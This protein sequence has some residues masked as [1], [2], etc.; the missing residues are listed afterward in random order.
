MAGYSLLSLLANAARGPRAWPPVWR[1]PEPKRH[2][3]VVIVGGGGHGLATAHYLA[4]QYGITDVAVLEKGWLGGGNTAR[5][6]TIVRSDYRL[7]ANGALMDFSLG[8]WEGL[9]REL[10]FNVM[11][12]PRGYVDLAHSDAELEA[13]IRRA[14]AMRLRG[15]DVDILDRAGLA[16][17]VPLLDCGQAT[18]FPVVGALVQERGGT[19]RH[20][21]VAWGYARGA[22][23]L[24]VDI[25]QN[26]PVSGL[27]RRGNRITGV[28]TSRGEIA[29]SRILLSVSGHSSQLAALAGL[30]LPIETFAVQAFVSEP[31][32]PVLDA[33]VNFNAGMAYVSQTAKGE[34]L[35]GGE[36]DRYNCYVQRGGFPRI[37]DVVRRTIA[38]FPFLA[39]LRLM[40]QWAGI[41][42]VT[43]DGG[44]ILGP[45]TIEGLYLNAG[46]G[47]SGFKATPA[48]GWALAHTIAN[49]APHPLIRPYRLE[50]FED[51]ELL[52]ETGAGPRPFAH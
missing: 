12:T 35:L 1:F 23:A 11:M 32:K 44:P 49:G 34:I 6:T 38:M 33:V 51:G 17:R 31:V 40:R 8:L 24:G 36:P 20:D 3:D 50:R 41:V 18:R 21:A 48:S 4:K 26:C 29:T 47:Y 42:D 16:A 2:Y 27:L 28:A 22:D 13:F 37:E 39:R 15:T 52:D 19:A 10:N 46:W 7:P 9:S 25:I 30:Q 43:M 14:N 5:N 45:T